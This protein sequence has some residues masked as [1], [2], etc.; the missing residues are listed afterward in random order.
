[1]ENVS[2]LAKNAKLRVFFPLHPNFFSKLSRKA[3][4]I[5]SRNVVIFAVPELSKFCEIHQ[6]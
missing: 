2:T 6:R 5:F 1:M 4:S 3:E